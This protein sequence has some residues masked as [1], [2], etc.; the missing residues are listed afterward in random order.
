M[1]KAILLLV[2]LFASAVSQVLSQ[3]MNR[4][5]MNTPGVQ[6]LIIQYGDELQLTDDQKNQ[7]LALQI[8]HRKQFQDYR[9]PANR[10]N[11]GKFRD[12]RS[13]NRRG[14]M[15]GQGFNNPEWRGSNWEARLEMRNEVLNILTEDQQEFL[16]AKVIEQ[17]ERA[18]EFRTFRHEYIVNEA[19]IEGDKA[20]QVLALLNAQSESH[21]DMAKQR[22]MNP[23]QVSQDL[24][25]NRFQQMR[26]T[27]DELRN[28]LTVDEYDNLRQNMG[29]GYGQGFGN[30]PQKKSGRGYRM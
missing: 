10:N 25:A 1:K 17:A 7:L 9:G 29:F 24:F 23:D 8:E 4:P 21:L 12:N 20:K 22:F 26:D 16:Q 15:R 13:G 6:Q 2:F 14:S 19:G 30:R 5:G 27:D 28:I 3:P 18:H 11:R